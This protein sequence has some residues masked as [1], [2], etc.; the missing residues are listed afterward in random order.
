MLPGN[1]A[2][3][4]GAYS[5]VGAPFGVVLNARF[6]L[7]GDVNDFSK[8][9]DVYFG[10]DGKPGIAGYA[11]VPPHTGPADSG[12]LNTNPTSGPAW[13]TVPGE[14]FGP[15]GAR[16]DDLPIDPT[17]NSGAGSPGA[18]TFF[19]DRPGILGPDMAQ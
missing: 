2:L 16:S 6:W 13:G 3:L 9:T 8:Q 15:L 11:D 7:G 4:R 18:N 17:F 12:I 14:Y 10:P 1:S 19:Y 5:P